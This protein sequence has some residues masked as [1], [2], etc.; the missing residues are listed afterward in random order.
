[1]PSRYL[2]HSK[3]QRKNG[4]INTSQPEFCPTKKRKCETKSAL[5]GSMARNTCIVAVGLLL[6]VFNW[7]CTPD[8]ECLV[9]I[10]TEEIRSEGSRTDTVNPNCPN[11]NCTTAGRVELRPRSAREQT[12]GTAT[13]QFADLSGLESALGLVS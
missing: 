6:L 5:H 1:M 8:S 9:E 11:S 13:F 10:Q 7:R 3:S 12:P 2:C 4:E